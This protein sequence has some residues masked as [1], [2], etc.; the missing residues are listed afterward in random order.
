HRCLAFRARVS[1]P[2]GAARRSDRRPMTAELNRGCSHREQ[3][4]RNLPS[5]VDHLA[6]A[7]VHANREEWTARLTAG[8]V[9]VGGR[10]AQEEQP[11][12]AGQCVTW[13]PPPWEEPPAPLRF[14]M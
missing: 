1:T 5:L 2:H 11:L 4:C 13:P 9:E 8:E 6:R 12:R 10:L 7:H 3:V 14:E